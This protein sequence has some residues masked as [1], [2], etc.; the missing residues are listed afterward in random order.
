MSGLSVEQLAR[1]A[2]HC[3]AAVLAP[4]LSA[5]AAEFDIT[6]PLRLAHFLG[7]CSVESKGL[8]SFVENLNYSAPRLMEVWPS[9]F[10]T[11]ASAEACAHNPD[12]LAV[13]VYSG[14][15]GNVTANDA[16]DFIGRGIIQL[17]GRDN[18]RR[19]GQMVGLDLLKDPHQ[20]GE[21]V[22]APRI[23]AAFWSAHGL[24]TLADADDIA[25]ITR[26]VNGGLTGLLDR[27]AAVKRA[28]ATLA[29]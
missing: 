7:Q 21:P 16:A 23:A 1:F 22:I 17:T 26:A 2:P 25:G 8:T 11:L 14:R 10:P 9:R 27:S 28:K 24:N 29:A 13:R 4:A 3:D 19:Y 12:A 6:T 15:M 20:A 18:Y 5:A